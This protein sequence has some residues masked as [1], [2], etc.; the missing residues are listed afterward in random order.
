MSETGLL[1]FF[2]PCFHFVFT[3]SNWSLMCKVRLDLLNA[4]SHS[5]F[6]STN[7]RE[8]LCLF[9]VLEDNILLKYLTLLTLHTEYAIPVP[10]R[11]CF[12]SFW[13]KSGLLR[14]E[15]KAKQKKKPLIH[16]IIYFFLSCH[17]FFFAAVKNVTLKG[18]SPVEGGHCCT[19]R[20]LWW[21]D[22]VWCRK[23]M[24][25]RQEIKILKEERNMS[26]LVWTCIVYCGKER[27][28][29]CPGKRE[30]IKRKRKCKEMEDRKA[31]GNSSDKMYQI[32]FY[33]ELAS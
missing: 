24:W 14:T 7:W 29:K 13:E 16:S 28:E 26:P 19:G 31:I 12:P 27:R 1:I 21:T 5:G 23:W 20:R 32:D 15:N 9:I 30:K 11:I 10:V 22:D 4:V 8:P 25:W 33:S 17:F 3:L 18:E 2:A 6:H